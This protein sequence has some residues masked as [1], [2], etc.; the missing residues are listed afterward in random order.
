M[1]DATRTIGRLGGLASYGQPTTATDL[2][3]IVDRVMVGPP[4]TT[5]PKVPGPIAQAPV[6]S[7]GAYLRVA[8][9]L[10]VGSRWLEGT[11]EGKTGILSWMTGS[12]AASLM[13]SATSARSKANVL[14]RVHAD[15]LGVGDDPS[16]IASILL[17]AAG[18]AKGAGAVEAAFA[19]QRLAGVSGI[20]SAQGAE[21]NEA[22]AAVA[23]WTPSLPSLP[24][25]PSLPG[26]PSL[27]KPEAPGWLKAAGLGVI[28]LIVIAIAGTVRR[29]KRRR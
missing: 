23:R 2:T 21:A 8:Y 26:L 22:V 16:T 24:S 29:R 14:L 27:P 4:I 12:P 19:L 13:M 1:L 3:A 15:A 11:G 7:A 6:N 25:W 5:W 28:L 20:R 9:W 10:A 17:E 18:Q